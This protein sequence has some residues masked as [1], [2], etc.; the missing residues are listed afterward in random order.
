MHMKR[1]EEVAVLQKRTHRL[2]SVMCTLLAV[3]LCGPGLQDNALGVPDTEAPPKKIIKWVDFNIPAEAMK[4]ALALDV[5]THNREPRLSWIELLA[6]L[7]AKNGNNFKNYKNSQLDDLAAKLTAGVPLSTL[8]ENLKYYPYYLEAYGAALS[9][10]VGAYDLEVLD[11]DG[12]GTH[13]E[14]RYGLRAYSPLAKNYA[15]RHYDDF[16]NKRS[17]GF[18]RSHLGHDMMAQ[19]GTPVIAVEGGTVEALGWNQYGGWRIGIRS[20]DRKR[21]YYYAHLRKDHPFRKDLAV[22]ALVKSGDVIG[23]LGRTGYSHKE[24]VSNIKT[25]HLHFGLQ[26]IFDES[27]KE[28][29]SEIWIDVYHIVQLLDSRRCE[30][31]K[32]PG[33]KDYMRRFDISESIV[34][35]YTEGGLMMEDKKTS[36]YPVYSVDELGGLAQVVSASE[37]TGLTPTPPENDAAVRAYSGLYNTP[38]PTDNAK[39][40]SRRKS[41]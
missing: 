19:V 36:G 32:C 20:H 1:V 8:T 16:G 11:K 10:L 27:Q 6:Y 12:K 38:Q 7:A 18:T 41:T 17:Y 5:Q 25:P 21:Y 2:V 30:V 39:A 26:L 35:C 13:W 31:R 3:L 34:D 9:G 33:T 14:T 40:Q 24:N 29:N 22:G 23:Y 28:C 37:C 15:Y 4:K